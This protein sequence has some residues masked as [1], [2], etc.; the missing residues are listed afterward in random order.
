MRLLMARIAEQSGKNELAQHLLAE[1]DVL[2]A[3]LSL[4]RLNAQHRRAGG[5]NSNQV[6]QQTVH[7]RLQTSSFRFAASGLTA[8]DRH[9]R[10]TDNIRSM[11]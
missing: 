10:V 11:I 1:L 4:A 8:D 2:A 9:G 3:T 6:R 7:L 5:V